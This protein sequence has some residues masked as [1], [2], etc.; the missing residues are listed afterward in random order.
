MTRF[1]QN[2]NDIYI[3]KKVYHKN[4]FNDASSCGKIYQKYY[5]L[6]IFYQL[7]STYLIP[8]RIKPE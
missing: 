1:V 6:N 5:S 4:K 2:M 3:S 7:E 8:E